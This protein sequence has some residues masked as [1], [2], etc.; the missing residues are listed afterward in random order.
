MLSCLLACL[1]FCFWNWTC[2]L[3]YKGKMLRIS[4]FFPTFI[5]LH[6]LRFTYFILLKN[7]NILHRTQKWISFRFSRW[8]SSIFLLPFHLHIFFPWK[9]Q[10][11]HF[12]ER[13]FGSF[14]VGFLCR[15]FLILT[16]THRFPLLY[17]IPFTRSNIKIFIWSLHD[18]RT[19]PS[20]HIFISEWEKQHQ[21]NHLTFFFLHLLANEKVTLLNSDYFSQ[22]RLFFFHR[23]D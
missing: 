2:L 8:V 7:S 22:M 12:F 20:W 23:I 5:L 19:H 14:R 13:G 10:V 18:R 4:I 15:S 11:F 9:R 6:S 16:S 1:L 17:R 21:T 3:I